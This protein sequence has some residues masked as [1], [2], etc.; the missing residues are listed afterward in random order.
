MNV[1]IC[2]DVIVIVP[3]DKRVRSD[4]AVERDRRARE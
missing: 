3:D 4:W 2:S 1:G